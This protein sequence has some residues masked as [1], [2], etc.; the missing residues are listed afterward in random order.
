MESN[1]Y[2]NTSATT[3]PSTMKTVFTVVKK[4][5]GK[6]FWMKLGV[7][8]VNRDG[9]INLHLDALPANGTLQVRDFDPNWSGRHSSAPSQQRRFDELAPS[10]SEIAAAE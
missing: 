1:S 6:S 4:S 8:F 2:S 5:D 7:G 3:Q 10:E 9:S